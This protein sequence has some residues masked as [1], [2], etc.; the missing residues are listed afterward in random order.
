M[1][2]DAPTYATEGE[3]DV[4][5]LEATAVHD[6]DEALT[7]FAVNRAHRAA[8]AARP[9]CTGS[10]RP[11]VAEHLVLA[12]DDPRGREHRRAA[13]PR[14]APHRVDGARVEAGDAARR[15]C[16]P[17]SWNVLRLARAA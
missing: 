11:T 3:D 14:P 10:A 2:A 15:R 4:P 13:G 16:P 9:R 17:R 1:E 6:G 7:L 8:R 5:V 12:D